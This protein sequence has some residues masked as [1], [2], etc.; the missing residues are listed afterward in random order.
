MNDRCAAGTGKFFEAMARALDCGLDGLSHL[1]LEAKKPASITNQCSVF[2]ESEVVTL[3]NE[4]WDV[5][6]IAAGIHNSIAA[7]LSSMVR[8]VGLTGDMVLTGGCA[9][10]EGL[11]KA[12]EDKMG[13]KVV[14]MSID[15]Q[16]N[17]AVGAALIAAEKVSQ[18][19]KVA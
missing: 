6:D 3:L 14:K 8:K 10:N 7:R 13:V 19:E 11:A 12:I 1:S 17:G 16:I 2:A 15:P 5:A 18:K 4:G 9:K